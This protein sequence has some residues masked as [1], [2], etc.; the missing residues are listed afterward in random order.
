MQ[1][2]KGIDI[3]ILI[4]LCCYLFFCFFIFLDFIFYWN[5][6]WTNLINPK[7]SIGELLTT[8]SS[9]L[10]AFTIP[11]VIDRTINKQKTK[12]E[13]LSSQLVNIKN[14]IEDLMTFMKDINTSGEWSKN[15]VAI[16]IAFILRKIWSKIHWI[17]AHITI[18][19]YKK[20][21]TAYCK[22]NKILDNSCS[23]DFSLDFK[24]KNK[25]Y[26]KSFDFIQFIDD[27]N[28][29]IKTM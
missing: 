14:D 25:F 4:T 1:R 26:N 2:N 12:S 18:E 16:Y 6:N 17:K 28:F 24:F 15:D 13:V 3:F 20:L 19:D 23:S 8:F 5:L 29:N 27:F 11:Y 10:L 9:I 7:V 22:F 21:L